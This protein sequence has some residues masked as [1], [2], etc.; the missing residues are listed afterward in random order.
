MIPRDL[1]LRLLCL[2]LA[3]LLVGAAKPV[4]R[5]TPSLSDGEAGERV[6][7]TLSRGLP[8]GWQVSLPEEWLGA[9][10][11]TVQIPDSWRGNPASAAIALCPDA[12][13]PVW[14]DMSVLRLVMRYQGRVWPP[15]DCRA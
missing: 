4:R 6:Q 14:R 1:R 15:Y 2:S 3:A 13:S 7:E 9:P 11:V 10:Q 5:A 12:N 8:A